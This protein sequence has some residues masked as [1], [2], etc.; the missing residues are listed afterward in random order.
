M[1]LLVRSEPIKIT[2]EMTMLDRLVEIFCEV[3]DFCKAFQ[4]AFESHFIGNGRGS[5]GPAPG[6]ADAEIITLLLVL[7]SSGFKS[8]KNFYN[9]PMGEVLRRYF[10][11]MPC[12]ER[13]IVLQQRALIPLMAFLFSKLGKKTGLYYI[14]STALPVCH[15]RRIGRHKAFAGLAA[16]G[17][18]SMGWFF[19]FKLPLVFHD[20]HE[21][22]ALKL[23][24]G[25]V[26][27]TAPVPALTKD[28][29]G[30]LF[31]DKGYIS[32]KLAGELLRR[33]LTLFTR[34][35]KNR[36][37]LPISMIDKMLLNGRHM[38][39]TIIGSSKGRSSLNLPKHRLP[40]NAF[41]HILAAMVAYQLDPI[42]PNHAFFS[43][44]PPA[45][46]AG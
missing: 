24:P 29:I 45:I 19:G 26:S 10:P 44:R 15:N 25:H 14:D 46:T 40:S 20:L 1:V 13:F 31:G 27:D 37:S 8:W 5:R 28:L 43:H 17:K 18:T 33:G 39:E 35:R 7:H 41:L 6:L 30:K 22:A 3:D 12:Y 42:K 34:V 9:S 32:K 21:I 4:D 11:G 36:K 38:A 2:I 23:T 16:R